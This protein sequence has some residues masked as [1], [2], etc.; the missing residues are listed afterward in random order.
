[1]AQLT[2][3]RLTDEMRKVKVSEFN[4]NHV[5]LIAAIDVVEYLERKKHS[6]A[7]CYFKNL[8]RLGIEKYSQLVRESK[9]PRSDNIKK[10]A[11]VVLNSFPKEWLE[12]MEMD[13]I[14]EDIIPYEFI[15]VGGKTKKRSEISVKDIKVA[16]LGKKQSD[17]SFPYNIKLGIVNH[18]N[19]NPFI[20][21]RVSNHSVA[22]RFFKYRLLHCDIYTK[23]RMLRF[24]MTQDDLCD[25]CGRR[26]DIRHMLWDCTRVKVMW[27]N[28]NA[29]FADFVNGRSI[30]F[31]TIFVGFAPTEPILESIIT[32]ITRSI[33]ARDRSN[34]L[35]VNVIKQEIVDHC[36]CNIYR[37][38][39]V[40][41]SSEKWKEIKSF[42]ESR[43]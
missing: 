20:A 13:N 22:L 38:T 8:F 24:K 19:I 5:N 18:E 31:E 21:S 4:A 16:L 42:I 6:L 43:L 41:K 37:L 27:E 7:L 30:T 1:M 12:L 29:V 9:F 2:I 11:E 17:L 25:F 10:L 28:I 26:E 14:N 35:S 39:K 15:P 33:V 32:R 40:G 34:S 3:N 36:I 23:E